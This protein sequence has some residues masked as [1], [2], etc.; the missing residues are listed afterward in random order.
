MGCVIV[1]LKA[2]TLQP[3]WS[4]IFTGDALGQRQMATSWPGVSVARIAF[5]LSTA[6]HFPTE[7]GTELFA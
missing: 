1:T 2:L 5:P 4:C 3:S 7:A 6:P